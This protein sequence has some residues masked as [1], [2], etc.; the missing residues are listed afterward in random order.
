MSVG[1]ECWE[2]APGVVMDLCGCRAKELTPESSGVE[3]WCLV[4]PV[5][6]CPLLLQGV[7]HAGKIQR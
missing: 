3:G 7:G 6:D 4:S 5:P 1:Q 2:K